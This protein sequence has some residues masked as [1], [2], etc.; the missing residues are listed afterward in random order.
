MTGPRFGKAYIYGNR[1]KRQATSDFLALPESPQDINK[2]LQ[3]VKDS[4][5]ETCLARVICELSSN[6]N[7]HGREGLEFGT[8]LL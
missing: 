2:L 4:N 5:G 3:F 8:T 6:P 1:K 7:A